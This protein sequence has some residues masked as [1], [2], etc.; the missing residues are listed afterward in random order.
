MYSHKRA[1]L[2]AALCG[3]SLFSVSAA[4]AESLDQWVRE[5]AESDTMA[6]IE[7]PLLDAYQT[8]L[9]RSPMTR[10]FQE[11]VTTRDGALALTGFALVLIIIL[12]V[13]RRWLLG[14]GELTLSLCF[15]DELEGEFDVQLFQK[16]QRRAR[17]NGQRGSASYTRSSVH[18]ETQFDR[19]PSGVWFL[20]IDGTLQA[21]ESRAVLASISEEIRVEVTAKQCASIDHTLEP[22]EAPIDLRVHWARQPA[23]D[24]GLCLRGRPESLRYAAQGRS[25]TTLP[26][27][28]HIMLIGAEDRVVEQ[29]IRIAS[30]EPSVVQVDLAAAEGLV[31]K[32]CPPAVSSFLRG[33]LGD[34]AR[35]LERDG[36]S[37]VA[38]LLLARLHQ[39]QGQTERAAEQL[40]NAGRDREAAELRRSMSDFDRAAMLFE[41]AG[42]LRFAAEMYEAAESWADA[43]RAFAAIEDWSDAERCYS[44][45]GDHD[46]LI[47]ALEAQGEL[48]RAAA[49]ASEH[50]DRARA[51][52]LLQQVGPKDPE[53]G[54]AGE[55]LA[56]AFEHEGHLDLAANQLE[57]RLQCLAPGET[58]PQLEIHLAELLDETGDWARALVVLETLRDREPTFPQVA[59]RIESL[60]K[61]LSGPA[62]NASTAGFSP[63]GGATAFVAEE[64]YE[65]LEEIGRG[66][67]GLVYKARDRR[68]GRVIALKRMPENLRDHPGAVQL[69]LGEAQAAAR[70]NH[71]NIV[72][73]YDV[74]QENGHF[75]ITMELLEGLPLNAILTKRGR[76]GPRDTVQLGAQIC[77]GLQFAHDQG[78]VHRD[79]KTANLFITRERMLKIMDFGLAKILE[80]V[81]DKGATLIAGTPFYMAPEQ[82][83]GAVTDGRTDLY[84]LGVT[85]FELSTGKLPFFEGD[86]AEQHRNSPPPNAADVVA[87]YPPAL[88]E[89]IQ[90]MMAKDPEERPASAAA[91]ATAL[92]RSITTD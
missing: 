41:N 66:G 50:D 62:P 28:D 59:S 12:G 45:A 72:T 47:G 20:S 34:A 3:L 71:P 75:F 51:I 81:R 83:A 25:R 86:V 89:L 87:D 60:R 1:I 61:K 21:P 39:E 64:R 30:Y 54:R 37:N 68:L 18:R 13:A 33:D 79:I 16:S 5:I 2:A 58:A 19:V 84:A 53:Y 4:S 8:L 7:E 55:L 92:A 17:T 57:R 23:R 10:R 9:A 14:S 42:D 73:L 11:L 91:V 46:A 65:I 36:Q 80:A 31:F 38:S 29:S 27:G 22:V 32:G 78:I 85:L 70:M 6:A 69:F 56:L 77:A 43:A 74:D 40:E 90:T 82:A 63:S 15:P 24:F 35:A 26:L 67:M 76:F 49:L 52:R 88:A 48:F 44:R